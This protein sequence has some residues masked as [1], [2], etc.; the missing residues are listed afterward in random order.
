MRRN[1]FSSSFELRRCRERRVEE[2]KEEEE[3]EEER[4]DLEITSMLCH[5][6]YPFCVNQ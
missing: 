1:S 4:T 5:F 2:E 3:E 6:S